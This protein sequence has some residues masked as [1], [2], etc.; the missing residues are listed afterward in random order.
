V[1][2]ARRRGDIPC[3]NRASSGASSLRL[4]QFFKGRVSDCER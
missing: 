4:S 1:H 2:S 3:R